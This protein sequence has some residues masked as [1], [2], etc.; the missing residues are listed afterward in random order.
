[1]SSAAAKVAGAE[2][3]GSGPGAVG[4]GGRLGFLVS[5]SSFLQKFCTWLQ[6]PQFDSQGCVI[7]A[8][9]AAESLAVA[10]PVLWLSCD[11]FR[12]NASRQQPGTQMSSRPHSS[13]TGAAAAPQP[14][15]LAT[16]QSLAVFACPGHRSGGMVLSSLAL[17]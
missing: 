13:D 5:F 9:A 12:A 3:A 15:Q 2:A 17:A 6:F 10:L 11:L 4:G 1:M 7:V 14:V 8:L 16:I